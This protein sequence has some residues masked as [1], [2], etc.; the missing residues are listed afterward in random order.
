MGGKEGAVLDAA[1]E[2]A[3]QH[4]GA[5]RVMCRFA[6]G[7]GAQQLDLRGLPREPICPHPLECEL[8][9][10]TGVWVEMKQSLP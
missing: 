6:G 8:F 7:N 9:G 5:G 4:V 3:A 2:D 10:L 1:R